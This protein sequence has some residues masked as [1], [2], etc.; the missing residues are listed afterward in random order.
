MSFFETARDAY[1]LAKKGMTIEFQV[2][3]MELREQGLELQEE[4]LQLR[5]R[6]RK[7]EEM[8]QVKEALVFRDSMYFLV[9]EGKDEGPFCSKCYDDNGKLVRLHALHDHDIESTYRCPVCDGYFGRSS[10]R[11][12][13]M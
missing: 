8:M 13:D 2:K 4:N 9:K 7:L 6:I 11:S 1:E 10:R 12:L 5:T 3:V